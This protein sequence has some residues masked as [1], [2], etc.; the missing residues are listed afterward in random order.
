MGR[1]NKVAFVASATPDAQQTAAAL[2]KTYGDTA[3]EEADA[4]VALG[5][6][7]LMLQTLHLFMVT[8]KPIYGMN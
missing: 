3:P 2:R 4:I 1:F 5:G 8:G 7:G 6:D